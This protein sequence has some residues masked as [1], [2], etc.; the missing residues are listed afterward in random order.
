MLSARF[1][2]C[3]QQACHL[4]LS[5]TLRVPLVA[6]RPFYSY[7][8]RLAKHPPN[9]P[10]QPKKTFAPIKSLQ[11]LRNLKLPETVRENI[12]TVPN[13]LTA[14]RILA[15]P[16]LGY[17]IVQDNFVAATALLLYAGLTD[18]VDGWLARTYNMRSVLGTILDPAA[19]K[20]LMTTLTIT[21]AVKSLI[22][23]V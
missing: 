4:R 6:T 16:A 20:I 5:V 13:L 21:L 18:L 23:C 14:S 22:P 9:K 11:N 1:Q 19:D 10:T 17:C 15:C 2:P 3:L 12:Y 7:R 8:P